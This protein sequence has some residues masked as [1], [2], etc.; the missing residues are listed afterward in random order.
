VGWDLNRGGGGV[1][2]RLT[3]A[4]EDLGAE[5]VDMGL[6]TDASGTPRQIGVATP[7]TRLTI[8]E[9]GR[10]RVPPA[11]AAAERER[12]A[13]QHNGGAVCPFSWGTA[14][15]KSLCAA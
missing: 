13:V 6:E 2:E 1:L 4:L 12:R 9:Q 14:P 3:N 5:E 15:S 7:H 10:R 11:R 8:R